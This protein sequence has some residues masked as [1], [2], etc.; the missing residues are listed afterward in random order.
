M[1][2]AL[3][4]PTRA[5]PAGAPREGVAWKTGTSSR[6]RDA[7][8]AGTTS[9]FTA[10]VWRGRLDGRPDP[11]LAGARRRC[12]SC[13]GCWRR[14][15]PIRP[16]SPRP[17]G[18][19][20]DTA[21]RA[22]RLRRPARPPGATSVRWAGGA[23]F[24]ARRPASARDLDSGRL[25]APAAREGRRVTERAFALDP[26]ALAEWRRAAG[27]PVA[28][29]PLHAEDCPAP[30]EPEA[31]APEIAAPRDGQVFVAEAEAGA[32]VALVARGPDPGGRLRVLVDGR[33]QAQVRSGER[34]S[35][36]LAGGEHAV[37]VVS[38][39]GRVASVR[40]R[41]EGAAA[42]GGAAAQGASRAR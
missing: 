6:R 5:R 23:P 38:D 35:L 25:G 11:A 26:P 13:S 20:V 19:G 36:L 7:W 28:S 14:W 16:P 30:L 40:V 18:R 3:A 8:A 21:R 27:L 9:R 31:L 39:R 4:D 12:R 33:P 24:L 42:E 37:V 17:R 41:V 22:A 32:R 10:V 34:T 2:Q 29:V 15:T 1:R